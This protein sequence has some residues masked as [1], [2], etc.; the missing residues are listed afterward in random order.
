MSSVTS[1]R[2]RENDDEELL[3][4]MTIFC[5]KSKPHRSEEE[6]A[7]L[8]SKQNSVR[9]CGRKSISKVNLSLTHWGPL[10]T[11]SDW[12]LSKP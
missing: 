10:L 7:S 4:F 12:T 3:I 2:R 9:V 6:D 1:W 8:L 11:K 5:A